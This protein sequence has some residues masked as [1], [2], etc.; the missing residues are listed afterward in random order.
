MTRL[1]LLG[2]VSIGALVAGFAR[3]AE[4][5]SQDKKP[6]RIL[7]VGNSYTQANSLDRLVKALLASQGQTVEIGGY[8]AGGRTLMAHWNE[9]L[10]TIPQDSAKD[11]KAAA[12]AKASAARKGQFDKL[13]EH[14]PWDYVVLQGQSRDTLDGEKWEFRKYA[15]LFVEKIRKANPQTKVLFYLTWARQHLSDEQATITKTYLEVARQ[16]DALVAPVGEAWKDAL[17]ARPG[18]VLHKDDKSHPNP[19]GSYLAGCVFYATITGRSPV[20]LPGKVAAIPG[21]EGKP[22]YDLTDAD[23][24]FLQEIA[25]KTVRRVKP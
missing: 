10:G 17:A 25:W 20:D 15:G 24:K 14:G 21:K 5:Q 13:L 23:A 4:I 11:E 22:V 2:F 7:F 3:A 6:L 12:A 9:N 16:H 1:V 19:M 8:L 18:L